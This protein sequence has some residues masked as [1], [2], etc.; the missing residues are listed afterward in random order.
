MNIV[1]QDSYEVAKRPRRLAQLTPDIFAVDAD[2]SGDSLAK[3]LLKSKSS[4]PKATTEKSIKGLLKRSLSADSY[5]K[6]L[7][8]RRSCDEAMW[9]CTEVVS[10]SGARG[11]VER[12]TKGSQ[13]KVDEIGATPGWERVRIQIDSG[14]TDTI[15]LKEIC[16]GV[17]GEGHGDAQERRRTCC[18]GRGQCRELLR[19]EDR[20]AYRRPTRSEYPSTTGECQRGIVLIAQDEPRRQ[21]GGP[22]WTEEPHVEQEHGQK[23]E[24]QLRGGAVRHVLAAA[25]EEGGR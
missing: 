5:F 7:H 14:A 16:Q 15:D 18:C 6:E 21:R 17:R 23:E 1:D 9:G 11:S 3:E 10:R 24:D 13:G 8:N 22:A 12:V 19:E 25:V 20:R 2:G 4:E